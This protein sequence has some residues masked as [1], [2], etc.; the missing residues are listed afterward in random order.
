MRYRAPQARCKPLL[1]WHAYFDRNPSGAR[2]RATVYMGAEV[3]RPSLSHWADRRSSADEELL[4]VYGAEFY[5][6]VCQ[7]FSCLL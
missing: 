3:L 5:R 1:P 2:S 4:D 6:R 7:Y